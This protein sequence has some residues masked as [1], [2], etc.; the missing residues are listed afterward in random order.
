MRR[1]LS[2]ML[3]AAFAMLVVAWLA[4]AP[5]SA[6][7]EF[8]GWRLDTSFGGLAVLVAAI[9]FV[10]ILLDRVWRATMGTP[11]RFAD[12]RQARRT[13]KGYEAVTRGLVA[14]ASGDASEARRQARSAQGKLG[15]APV[16]HLLAAQAAQLA[17]D[18]AD[19]NKYLEAMRAL[20]ETEFAALRGLVAAA[21]KRG[22]T[23]QALELA[24]R[25]R[26]AARCDLGVGR[27]RRA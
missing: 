7:V 14:I 19:A 9:G 24:R 15:A 22:E 11:K 10:L 5:G 16:V 17:G 23:D 12:W 27:P 25:A 18:E 21:I 13:C 8:A 26:A 6:S 1:T 2:L 4:G 3:V 20:P